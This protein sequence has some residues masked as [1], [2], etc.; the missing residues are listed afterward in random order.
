MNYQGKPI[1]YIYNDKGYLRLVI[2]DRCA[3]KNSGK[4][5]YNKLDIDKYVEVRLDH[6]AKVFYFVLKK[7]ALDG[8]PH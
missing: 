1:E 3:Y 4:V 2:Y 8:I 7:M 5:N 6:L